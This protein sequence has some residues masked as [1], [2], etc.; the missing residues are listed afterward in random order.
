MDKLTIY[1]TN[2]DYS[3][4]KDINLDTADM[5]KEL[6]NKLD[7]IYRKRERLLEKSKTKK[8]F[9]AKSG[10][11]QPIRE[12]DFSVALNLLDLQEHNIR[13]NKGNN[14]GGIIVYV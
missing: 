10:H 6:R 3:W 8:I 5:T 11:M 13:R 9:K 1:N 14:N 4:F 7:S 12:V 2:L